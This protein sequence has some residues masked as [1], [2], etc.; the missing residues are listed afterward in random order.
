MSVRYDRVSVPDWVASKFVMTPENKLVGRAPCTNI[1]VFTYLK[2]D[3]SVIRE[4]RLP[5]EVFSFD[6]MESLKDK[7]IT[8]G[9]TQELIPSDNSEQY[10]G[11]TGNN[12][13]N[14]ENIYLSI[15]MEIFDSKAIEA[16]KNGKNYLSCAYTCDVEYESGTWLGMQYDAI[17]RNIRYGHVAIVDSP[18]AGETASIRLDSGDAIME[19]ENI[20]SIKDEEEKM[21]DLDK[22]IKIDA[23]EVKDAVKEIM[24]EHNKQLT[25]LQVK[26]DSLTAE[27]TRVE[28]ERDTYKDKVGLLEKE[29]EDLKKAKMDEDLI[30]KRVAKRVR[31]IEA[32][33]AVGVEVKDTMSEQEIQKAVILKT[34]PKADLENKDALYLD[35]RFDS[36]LEFIEMQN[37]ATLR[38]VNNTVVKDSDDIVKKAK[39]AYL[40]RLT[41][42][43]VEKK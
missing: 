31:I 27:K 43:E 26:F 11:K 8:L 35:A 25:E 21:A 7:K 9:H 34:F 38:M 33:K 30:A 29:I 6:S 41:K 40:Q 17:Q 28:A 4:L 15:D 42:K 5:E 10:V 12:P 32:A 13:I 18:R 20:I 36:A 22:T 3:G 19:H 24:E 37:D 16:I 23:S 1:G 39:D 2:A 14:G